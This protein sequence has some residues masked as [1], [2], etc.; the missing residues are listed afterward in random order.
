MA[1]V[2]ITGI[3]GSLAQLVGKRLVADGNEVIGID[4]RPVTHLVS[5]DI[6]VYRANYN[7]TRIEDIVRRHR[8]TH[9]LHLGRVGN[10]KEQMNK[11]FDLNVVGSAKIMELCLKHQVERL[12]VL[13]TF[14]IYGAH[15]HNHI[16]IFEDEPLRASTTFPQIGDAVQLDSMASQWVYRHRKL[17]TIVLRPANVVGPNIKNAVSTYLRQPNLVYLMGFS[18]MWQFVHERD[19][20][21]AVA[22]ASQSSNVGVYNV[23]GNGALPLV[24]ALELTGARLLPV[25]GA[26]ADLALWLGGRFMRAV[27]S[28]LLDFL[29]YPVIISDAKFREELGYKATGGIEECI[30]DTVRP[31]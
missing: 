20:V 26:A 3:A 21:D 16:P 12:V 22:L 27:P 29:R 17:K 25:P 23:A 5:P 6:L 8:P 24:R 14:H 13:S 9:V 10:L 2:L 19:M 30:R 4:Y 1:R 18:P 31:N 28:Y 15:P 7:K 11:R